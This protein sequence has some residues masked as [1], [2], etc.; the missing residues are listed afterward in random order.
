MSGTNEKHYVYICY[1]QFFFLRA[2]C[3]WETHGATEEMLAWSS[4]LGE[5]ISSRVFS[6]SAHIYLPTYNS[7]DIVKI[8]RPKC[9]IPKLK[10]RVS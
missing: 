9:S 7:H 3:P 8:R 10:L 2:R 5:I 1:L 4:R 6:Y